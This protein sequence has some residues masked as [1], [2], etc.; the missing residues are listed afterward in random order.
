M[1]QQTFP[2]GGPLN[3]TF[4]PSHR[5][6]WMR[7]AV[8]GVVFLALAILF[9]QA[10]RPNFSNAKDNIPWRTNLTDALA[11]SRKTGKPVLVDFSASWCGPC[12]EMKHSAWPDKKVEDAVKQNYIPVLLDTDG[13]EAEGPAKHY[14]VEYIPAVFI[15]DAD[16][17]VLRRG[18]FMSA[19]DL[20]KFLTSRTK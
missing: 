9:L 7:R 13:P 4:A 20:L 11:E 2:G 14:Q 18:D 12:Q 5:R 8:T 17:N 3:Y 15:L 10:T 6:K 16:G 19:S 1:T